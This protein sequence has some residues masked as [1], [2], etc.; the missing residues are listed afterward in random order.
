MNPPVQE[1]EGGQGGA[2]L[3]QEGVDLNNP[4]F[5]ANMLTQQVQGLLLQMVAELAE[6]SRQLFEL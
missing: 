3:N 5:F 2:G 6:T 1:E 4:N